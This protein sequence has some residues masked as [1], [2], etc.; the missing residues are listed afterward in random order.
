MT[1]GLIAA[2]TAR[3]HAIHPAKVG[4]DYIDTAFLAAAAGNPAVNLDLWAMRGTLFDRL[5]AR[6]GLVV[7]GVM[8]LFDGPSSGVGSSADVA[9]R[10]G[11]PV[12]LVVN[13]ERMSHSVAALVHGFVTFDP[14]VRVA[15]VILTRVGSARHE[16]M[17]RDALARSGVPCL[18]ALARDARSRC[19]RATSASRRR[20]RTPTLPPA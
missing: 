18:G 16:A 9:P 13:A 12:I 20:A 17:L 8:G 6:D 2:L 3:G 19:P 10:L 15:G 14:A 11:L 7:E 1:T 4:P 5:A